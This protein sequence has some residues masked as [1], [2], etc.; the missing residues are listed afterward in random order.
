MVFGR[1]LALALD[2]GR[3]S[4]LH[5]L[6]APMSQSSMKLLFN[7]APLRA[8]IDHQEGE[9]RKAVDQ[10][11]A[12]EVRD[13]D[14]ATIVADIFDRFSLA[15]VRFTEG[16]ISAAAE[17]AQVDVSGSWDRAIMDRSRPF[18]VPG[19]RVSYFVP[20]TGDKGLFRFQPSTYSSHGA[21]ADVRSNELAFHFTQADNDVVATKQKFEEEFRR[22]KEWTAWVTQDAERFN[23]TLPPTISRLVS[24]RRARLRQVASGANTL[25][26]PI[27]STSTV[28]PTA[29][30]QKAPARSKQPPDERY[31]V[32]L[33]FAGEDRAYV[34]EVAAALKARGVKVFYDAYEK[35]NMWG[36]NLVEHLAD[37]Y[38][39][40]SRFVVMFISKHYVEK[41]WPTHER[42]HA[43]AR[44]LVAKEEYILPARFDDTEVPGMTTTVGYVDLRGLPA[45]TLTDLI[46]AKLR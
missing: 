12:H 15:P 41:A 11:P 20:F 23:A 26:I 36:K 27:R 17:E 14:E 37:V 18:Y 35:A 1:K 31:D 6:S 33:S 46:M 22:V 43:Q 2:G 30:P 32:A 7:E 9:I 3:I 45:E 19:V 40:R 16:A 24:E 13:G 10:V 42:R 4:H 34:E 21:Y 44:A 5:Q 28:T 25:G 39:K 38:Q 29:Q 8:V